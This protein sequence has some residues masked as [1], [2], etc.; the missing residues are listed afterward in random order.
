MYKQNEEHNICVKL[1]R[2]RCRCGE[3]I[4]Y[5]QL[6]NH[7]AS[8]KH[9]HNRKKIFLLTRDN[10]FRCTLCNDVFFKE[11]DYKK[12]FLHMY[13]HDMITF[14]VMNFVKQYFKKT[15]KEFDTVQETDIITMK[16]KQ[17]FKKKTKT[18]IRRSKLK[19]ALDNDEMLDDD[20]DGSV[21]IDLDI[22]GTDSGS[23]KTKKKSGNIEQKKKRVLLKN[24]SESERI[25]HEKKQKQKKKERQREQRKNRPLQTRKQLKLSEEELWADF[26]TFF[27][28]Q[29]DKIKAKEQ[30]IDPNNLY[31]FECYKQNKY[32]IIKRK[33]ISEHYMKNH[34]K[35]KLTFEGTEI[36]KN[37]KD[38][39]TK[40][41]LESD[42]Y[43][44]P[45]AKTQLRKYIKKEEENTDSSLFDTL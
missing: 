11:D 40:L 35:F 25:E 44:Y 31:C 39:L 8:K 20:D 37:D 45:N 30:E 3:E 27:K 43:V 23:K 9:T 14:P 2:N 10:E 41:I 29:Q 26:K 16:I 38:K 19:Q 33:N 28:K 36:T 34:D 42:R 12:I 32:K 15:K 4:E 6:V 7:Y 18:K 13:F 17:Y 21:E 24:L 1:L 5:S 22:D